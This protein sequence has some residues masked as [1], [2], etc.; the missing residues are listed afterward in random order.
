M[1]ALSPDLVSI[2]SA[3]PSASLLLSPEF[4]IEAVSD[5]YLTA[6]STQRANLVGHYVFDVFP[7]N[8]ND[9]EAHAVRDV[10]AAMA[11]VVATGQP[12]EQP[13]QP[14]DIPDPKQPGRFIEHYW[15][16]RN[17]PVL[18]EQAR[19]THIIHTVVDITAQMQAA[20]Q[21]Q[22][23]Q[24]REQAASDAAEWQRGELARIFEQAPV[25]IAT[26]RGPQFVIELANPKV[27]ELWDRTPEQALG[28]PLFKLLPE[29]T[30]QGFDDLLNEVMATGVPHVAKEMPSTIVRNGQPEMVYWNFVYLPLREDDGT[31]TGAMV[32][33]TEVSEQVQA[34]QQIQGLNNQLAAVNRALHESNAELLA[35]QE[36]VLQVQQLL[37]NS[38]AERTR[39]LETALSEAEQHRNNA[40]QQQ[41]L[42]SQ[43]LGQVPASIATLSGPEHRYS[44]FNE[45]YQALSGGRTQLGLTVAEV[46]P[47]VVEQGFIELLDKVYATGVPF[48]GRDTPAQLYDPTTGRPELR[49]VDF[50]YQ[51][52]LSDQG[53]TLGVLAFII[54]VTD[55]VLARQQAEALQAQLRA[56][57]P[58]T[59]E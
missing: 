30:G 19:V 38:V 26:Y 55:G 54:D 32:V 51:P 7:D 18:D 14:Y 29:I 20:T 22:E 52:L 12:H 15:Q 10:R 8:P 24:V 25:A 23:A 49:Y 56:G 3:L 46:F 45:H 1:P 9:P 59:A 16:A 37:E 13:V 31:I 39:Q 50:S 6:S 4:V 35:N 48:I 21:L 47:E 2:F 28:T 11:Q 58:G 33:A 42:L 27:L 57:S 5:A 43:I 36:E 40:A 41:R 44:F 17:V 53:H 34:R